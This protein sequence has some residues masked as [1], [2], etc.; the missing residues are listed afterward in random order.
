MLPVRTVIKRIRATLH[1]SDAVTYDDD[2]L[3]DALNNGIRFIRRTIAEV[4]PEILMETEKGILKPGQSS[5]TLKERPLKVVRVTAGSDVISS[6]TEDGE[7]DLIYKNQNL[8]Y[9]NQDLI[10]VAPI[11]TTIYREKTLYATNLRHI[12]D[13]DR[14]GSPKEYYR[15]G[16]KNIHFWPVPELETAYTVDA[17]NDIKE[18]TIDD[19]SPLL[20]DFDDFIVE[21]VSLRMAIGNEY[22]ESQE[23]QVMMNIYNQIRELLAPP[24]VGVIVGGYWD[25]GQRRGGGY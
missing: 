19:D 12:P 8:I 4:Q 21:Y 13:M 18:L 2:E 10:Y 7:S 23:T 20:S 15:T 5:V 9:N 1:D 17:I 16:M 24:P 14:I 25:S 11:V 6:T 22:D 3:I